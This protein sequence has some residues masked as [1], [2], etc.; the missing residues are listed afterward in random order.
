MTLVT[1]ADAKNTPVV[2]EKSCG[3]C[4]ER[5]AR[6]QELIRRARESKQRENNGEGKTSINKENGK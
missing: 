5:K 2:K 4:A 3:C 1:P 6:V